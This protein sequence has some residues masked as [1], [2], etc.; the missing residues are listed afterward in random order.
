[1]ILVC[2]VMQRTSTQAGGLGGRT[3]IESVTG[4]TVDISEYLDLRFYDQVWY[5]RE[6]DRPL[7]GCVPLCREIDV[8]LDPNGKVH[9]HLSHD[10][11][12]SKESGKE[13]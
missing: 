2:K 4:E 8:V 6:T 9:S 3:L 7:V 12:D 11:A 1:M 5:R 13:S 10:S